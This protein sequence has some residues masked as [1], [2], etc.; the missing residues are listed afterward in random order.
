MFTAIINV[1]KDVINRVKT[2][3]K[4]ITKPATAN[5]AIALSLTCQ[6]TN[7]T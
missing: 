1:C 5:L 3:H 7:L 2:Q 6:R 4:K